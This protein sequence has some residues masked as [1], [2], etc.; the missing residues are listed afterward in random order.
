M[1]TDCKISPLGEIGTTIC[2]SNAT[3]WLRLRIYLVISYGKSERFN[4]SDR[5]D[6]LCPNACSLCQDFIDDNSPGIMY[7]VIVDMCLYSINR[8]YN[9]IKRDIVITTEILLWVLF[10]NSDTCDSVY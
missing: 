9:I 6:I 1:N 5:S 8:L 2:G 3:L 4:I 7:I 10:T